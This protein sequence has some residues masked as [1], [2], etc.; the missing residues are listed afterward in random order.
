MRDE[1]GHYIILKGSIQQEDLPILNIYAPNV[2]AA[3]Y[4]NQIITK[5]KKYL[6]NYYLILGD[7]NLALSTLDRSS[8]HN[9]SKE[10]RA[11]NDTLDQMDFTDIYRTLYP[12]STEY[13]FF[14]SAH[15][16][17]FLQNRP[18]TG[19]QIGSEPIP[20]DWDRP[21]I[22]SDHN[23]L[24]LELNPNKKFGRTSNTWRLRTILLKDDRVNQEIKEELKRFME[25]NENEDT[26][27]QNLW[28]AAKAVLRGKYIT[29]R[30]GAANVENTV[31]GP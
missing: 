2:G 7:F 1:E 28:D 27:V 5:V 8:K 13:T 16:T 12:N 11:L 29:I 14:S 30:T 21:C 19:S 4:L 3:K 9:I 18:H 26:T 25:T 10:T 17:F 31:E 6:D 22:F 24:K 20:K 15:G 23:A